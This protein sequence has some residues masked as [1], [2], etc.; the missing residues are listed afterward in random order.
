VSVISGFQTCA[1]LMYLYPIIFIS[2]FSTFRMIPLRLLQR[3]AT[4]AG[5][6]PCY[7]NITRCML[8]ATYATSAR[9]RPCHC[10]IIRCLPFYCD[11]RHICHNTMLHD[12]CHIHCNIT[13]CLPNIKSSDFITT[14]STHSIMLRW[15]PDLRRAQSGP[16]RA[17]SSFDGS[18]D[19]GGRRRNEQLPY[20]RPDGQFFQPR[21]AAAGRGGDRI[22]CVICLRKASSHN[23]PINQCNSTTNYKGQDTFCTRDYQTEGLLLVT[24]GSPRRN[25]CFKFNRTQGT[26]EEKSSASHKG[27]HICS[28]CGASDHGA[29][30][31]PHREI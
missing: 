24:R 27:L 16:V 28:G 21:G 19:R 17:A 22:I 2:P 20:S 29:A 15:T 12:I 3:H 31:C 14:I 26:C 1:V 25:V 18:A 9:L 10:D 13:R 11:V 30:K 4:Y 6:C 23:T 5:V 8:T 7:C